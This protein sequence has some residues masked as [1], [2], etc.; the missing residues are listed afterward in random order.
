MRAAKLLLLLSVLGLIALGG[1]RY[2]DYARIHP[3]TADAY[4][5]MH[6]VRVAAQVSG[7]LAKVNVRNHEAVKA[8][9][10]LFEIDPATFE[11]AVR[12]AQ[13]TLDQARNTQQANE[14]KV[15]A[16]EARVRAAEAT[17]EEA[18]RHARRLKSLEGK[19]SV[20]KD[21]LDG[22]EQARLD[23]HDS[24][25]ASKAE[26]SAAR[27]VLGEAGEAN[28]AIQAAKANL[29]QARLDL[30]HT[31]VSAPAD[32][33]VAEMD[34]RPGGYISAGR[35]M[36]ALVEIGQVWVDANFKETDLPRIRPGQ[37]AE[38]QI[39]S[40]PGKR[41]QGSVE[42]LSPASGTAFSLLPPENAT[43]NWVKVSQRFP[44]RIALQDPLPQMRVGASS[45][46]S[47]DTSGLGE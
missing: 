46:V 18:D 34:L 26:L 2:Y 44:V 20:S 29:D 23:A 13:A 30:S 16:A 47:I 43:G 35:E 7:T 12:K 19:G 41:F 14:A 21:R 4:L 38:I 17:F 28:A 27:A 24:L 31:Q 25:Q 9:Q 40:L 32:G 33:V 11:L 5:G 8:G 37:P 6:V 3:N 22:A 15:S 10:V 1:W 42:S 39:D 45:E 36:F